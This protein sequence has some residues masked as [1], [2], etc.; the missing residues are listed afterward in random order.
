MGRRMKQI[1][2]SALVVATLT[3]AMLPHDARAQVREGLELYLGPGYFSSPSGREPSK[4]TI[5]AGATFWVGPR[6]GLGGSYGV[7]T[8]DDLFEE[9]VSQGRTVELLGRGKLRFWRLMVERR[10]PVSPDL[11]L[12]AGVG[13]LGSWYMDFK[14]VPNSDPPEDFER[15]RGSGYVNFEMM[16][17]W[18]IRGRFGLRGGV[19]VSIPL[20]VRASVLASFELG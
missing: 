18:R 16:A 13:L 8:S 1:W 5:E 15:Q 14:R 9:P 17:R 20:V 4:P 11:D 10:F 12:L 19:D 7:G 2:R 6:W 3:L